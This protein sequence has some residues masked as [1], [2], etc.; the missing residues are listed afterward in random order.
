MLSCVGKII[1]NNFVIVSEQA[2]MR[3]LKDFYNQYKAYVRVDLV[4]YAVM[5]LLIIMYFIYTV[6]IG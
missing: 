3:K 4:M 2:M 1:I 6:L 5:I